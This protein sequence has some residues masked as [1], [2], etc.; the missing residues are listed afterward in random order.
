MLSDSAIFAEQPLSRRL[1]IAANNAW[2]D[3]LRRHLTGDARGAD[4]EL[5]HVARAED[6]DAAVSPT[7]TLD[8][9]LPATPERVFT[10]EH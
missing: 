9:V 2:T 6:F 1:L 3:A 8:A 10:G 4:I 7:P 5:R